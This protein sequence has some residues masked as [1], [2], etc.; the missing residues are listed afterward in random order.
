[1]AAIEYESTRER[2]CKADIALGWV[3]SLNSIVLRLDP[4]VGGLGRLGRQR[5]TL[6]VAVPE[7]PGRYCLRMVGQ[8]HCGEDE[9]TIVAPEACLDVVP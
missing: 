6:Q 7:K 2:T 8:H 9:F 4:I 1:M 5:N 3:D